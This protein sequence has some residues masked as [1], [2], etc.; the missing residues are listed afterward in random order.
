MQSG[1]SVN[2]VIKTNNKIRNPI[3][4]LISDMYLKIVLILVCVHMGMCLWVQLEPQWMCAGQKT[5]V[6]VGS[7]FLPYEAQMLNSSPSQVF[8]YLLSHLAGLC[9]G[10]K[11][12]I[13]PLSITFFFIKSIQE[14]YKIIPLNRTHIALL[15]L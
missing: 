11:Q 4:N 3:F 6:G 2:L 13:I 9:V 12:V 5:T 8:L 10:F 7:P 15:V 1:H 14:I